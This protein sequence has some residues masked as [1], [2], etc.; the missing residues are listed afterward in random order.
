MRRFNPASAV[1]I[2]LKKGLDLPLTGAP[3]QRIHESPAV[4]S[5][6]LVG[7]DYVG[8]KPTMLVKQGDR[9]RLG[10]ALFSDK[11][12]PGVQYTAPGAGTVAAVNRGAKRALLSVVIDLEGDEEE[13][14]D[15]YNRNGLH[16]LERRQVVENLLRSGLWSALRTRPYSKSPKPAATPRSIFVNAMDT[17][18]LAADPAVVIA[19]NPGRFRDGIRILGRLADTVHVCSAA[20]AAIE[21]PADES[22]IHARFAGPHPAGAVGTHIHHLDPVSSAREVWHLGYQ[23]VMAVGALFVEGRLVVDRVI[24]LGGPVVKEPRLLKT[25]LGA[26][27]EDLVAEQLHKQECRVIS[28]SVLSGRRAT[29]RLGYLGRYNTQVS[30]LPESHEREWLGWL[31]PGRDKYSAINVFVS[32]F[33]R[34]R[35]FPMTTS[36]N[37]SPRA[38]VPL[39]NYEKVVPLDMLPTQLLRSL[40]VGDTDTA[41][42][43]G[44]LELDEEDLALCSFVCPGKYDYGPVLRECLGRIEKEG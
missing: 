22:V 27:T 39:G 24:A 36:Q 26:H 29:N 21:T 11:K 35:K 8:M 4:R 2:Q 20:G 31:S 3:K 25:R 15:A 30:V 44:C 14:F 38:M 17:N 19:T 16:A 28:G 34:S 13:R 7:L 5:V 33:N 23:D 42:A 12:N 37:G 6:A 18:P 32:S 40:L 9:V 41:Q 43:L 10:Q 1:L